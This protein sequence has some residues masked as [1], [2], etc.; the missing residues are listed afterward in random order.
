MKQRVHPSVVL[1]V[2]A[3]M[4]VAGFP[5]PSASAHLPGDACDVHPGDSIQAAVNA[6]S[7]GATIRA[8]AGIYAES[9]LVNTDRI[10]L[11]GEPG[12]VLDGLALS[13]TR[14]GVRIGDGVKEFDFSGFEVRNY[15]NVLG[16]NNPSSGIVALGPSKNVRI[17]SVNVHDNGWAGILLAKGR[18]DTWEIRD[19]NVSNHAF[20]GIFS[21]DAK[22]LTIRNASLW[23]N[24][25]GSIAAAP[26]ELEI[27]ASTFGGSGR[28][29]IAASP[30]LGQ[31]GWP[32]QVRIHN[33][34]ITGTWT[35]GV[36]AAGLHSSRIRDNAIAVS[37]AALTLGGNPEHVFVYGNG[38]GTKVETKEIKEVTRA[39]REGL[40]DAGGEGA[41]VEPFETPPVERTPG[42]EPAEVDSASSL[43]VQSVRIENGCGPACSLRLFRT[44]LD[45]FLPASSAQS[46]PPLPPVGC[47][48]TA[49]CTA[50]DVEALYNYAV[51]HALNP[52][53]APENAADA[54][55]LAACPATDDSCL[56]A[57]FFDASDTDPP[58]NWSI[59]IPNDPV[60][61]LVELSF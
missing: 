2:L 43:A 23:N 37:G 22:R 15:K 18:A 16:D 20:V 10:T 44:F 48:L 52:L 40:I 38:P 58:N 14:Y 53:G 45:W 56:R 8:C 55:R 57:Q 50:S 7:P 41:T 9:V 59:V 36:W 29:A 3:S 28:A 12:A 51:E 61:G 24:K 47:A 19:S 4:L 25:Y 60:L 54:A 11:V 49:S 27:L 33:N 30:N 42:L 1:I 32:Q 13:G 17:S 34:S 26:L 46:P 6:A 39:F 21:Q 5:V 31:G 35:H